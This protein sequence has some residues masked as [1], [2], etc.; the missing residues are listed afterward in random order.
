MNLS[1]LIFVWIYKKINVIKKNFIKSQKKFCYKAKL[2]F[3][4]KS[5]IN[6]Q[7][8]YVDINFQQ[9]NNFNAILCPNYW[10]SAHY[11]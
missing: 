7:N 4:L 10:K 3:Y 6:K 9:D 2:I 8:I 11:I 1:T 5:K